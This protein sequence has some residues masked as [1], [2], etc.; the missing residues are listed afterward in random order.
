[1]VDSA[2]S[3][4]ALI[5][6]GCDGLMLVGGG[7]C[8]LILDFGYGGSGRSLFPLTFVRLSLYLSLVVGIFFF[9]L[10]FGLI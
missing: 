8:G 6:M 1:M 4:C 10:Q 5:F 3:G 2:P 9:L 7:G